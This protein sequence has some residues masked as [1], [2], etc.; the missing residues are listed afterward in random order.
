MI[1][2]ASLDQQRLLDILLRAYEKGKYA[3]IL[4]AKD[5]IKD[6]TA[7]LEPLLTE[8]AVPKDK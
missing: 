4:E 5:I 3:D 7:S 2:E 8:S 1:K 6:M